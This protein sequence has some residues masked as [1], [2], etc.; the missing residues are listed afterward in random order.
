MKKIILSISFILISIIVFAQVK[1][2]G[3]IQQV[4]PTDNYPVWTDSTGFGGYRVCADT[5]IRNS[6][7]SSFRSEGM[8]VYCINPAKWY[9]LKGGTTNVYW[10]EFTGG[11]SA[12]YHTN[13]LY[14]PLVSDTVFKVYSAS[15]GIVLGK[16]SS[17][18][19]GEHST[20]F[21]RYNTAHDYLE[22]VLGQYAIES[23][24]NS[25]SFATSNTAFKIG[26]G[27]GAGAK[28]DCFKI[29]FAGNTEISGNLFL[30]SFQNG[31]SSDSVLTAMYSGGK[32]QIKRVAMPSGMITVKQG[33]ITGDI[34][35]DARGTNSTDF[36]LVRTDNANVCA[37]N[38]SMIAGG[39][40][41]RIDSFY[42]RGTE[43]QN[44]FIACG[45]YNTIYDWE[46]LASGIGN[47][48]EGKLGIALGNANVAGSH[49]GAAI[50][51]QNYT[52]RRVF[53]D[54]TEGRDYCSEKGD[55]FNYV[56]IPTS[57]YDVRNFFPYAGIDSAVQR[58]GYGCTIDS[59]GNVYP[60]TY[61]TAL[62]TSATTYSDSRDLDWSL[63]SYCIVKGGQEAELE[64][65]KIIYSK[66]I[67]GTGT[68]VY[69]EGS[70][71]F[72]TIGGILSS[73]SSEVYIKYRGDSLRQGNGC[74]AMGRFANA[75]GYGA[76][77]L[78]ANT[79]A[80]NFAAVA[81]GY[82]SKSYKMGSVAVGTE[83]VTNGIYSFAGGMQSTTSG[84]SA[85]A[86]GYLCNATGQYSV[87]LGQSNT[88]S[89]EA[90]ICGGQGGTSSGINS[91]AFG[92]APYSSAIAS[93]SLG[94]GC[95][96]TGDY[97][98]TAGFADTASG[99]R[100]VA[101]GTGCGASGYN[102]IAIG[103]NCRSLNESAV[104][105][106]FQ[107]KSL[108][109][110]SA[111]F[112]RG[113]KTRAAYSFSAGYFSEVTA[114]GLYGV[115]VGQGVTASDTGAIALNGYTTASA[116][117]SLAAGYYSTTS[118]KNSAALGYYTSAHDFGELAIG[119]LNTASTGNS[120]TLVQT[121][122]AFSLGNG[123]STGARNTSVYMLFNGT[124]Y[125][126]GAQINKP[127]SID[128]V[129]AVGGITSAMLT[130]K[131]IRIFGALGAVDIT[132]NPQIADGDD[133]QIIEIWGESDTKTVKLDDGDGL[134]LS[135]GT[136]FTLGLGDVIVLRYF[137]SVDLW[138][139]IS[140]SD[141]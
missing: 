38:N 34:L 37:A 46:G 89:G 117:Y 135:G 84:R 27:T 21:G 83:C 110:Y 61:D 63:A 138:R 114:S 5:I 55:T 133:G 64:I 39:I 106:G 98:F 23:T 10:T 95:R 62:W 44:G 58:Y 47:I 140:R 28:N 116:D 126:E 141:N 81:L 9:Y 103:Q 111:T 105:M 26:C 49:D 40:D 92:Y 14:S 19:S 66:Y 51:N 32:Y 108:A 129:T 104:A 11:S 74:I 59:K 88:A 101:I 100:S 67:A 121:N 99:A 25:S 136:S 52:G 96:A 31:T 8:M 30:K 128:S 124:I 33:T 139:E 13:F 119:V 72:A 20:I 4:S 17:H 65:R 73:Y 77:S 76:I 57:Y 115:A 1:L 2:G 131:V 16:G 123:T 122:R 3:A 86:L 24:G 132:A 107:S 60:P 15:G 7:R 12:D 54:V 80:G 41:N 29:D 36:Q 50:G 70:K 85:I 118:G 90:A 87:A 82:N 48:V 45:R 102:S 112:N 127:S 71:P 125:S 18:A 113:C 120:N 109:N 91:I 68:K 75:L 78:G 137:S 94:R 69:Y 56:I 79:Y 6:I 134:Q 22:T 43:P 53:L 97:S 130:K 35:G 42:M 93:V